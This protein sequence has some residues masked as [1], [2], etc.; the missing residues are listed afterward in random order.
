MLGKNC[1]APRKR[2]TAVQPP[3][4]AFADML[5][6]L[7]SSDQPRH[8]RGD[9]QLLRTIE[10]FSLVE[11]ATALKGNSKG[12]CADKHGVLLEMRV[13]GGELVQDVLL[14]I[15]NEI[16][17]TGIFPHDWYKLIF[18]MVPKSGDP[19]D[20]NN[21]RPIA[22]LDVVYKV[23]AKILYNRL[24][25]ILDPQQSDEQFGF[26]TDCGTDEALMILE[27]I[28]GA[29]LEWNL[30]LW[31]LSVDLRKAFDKLEHNALLS[32]LSELG[33][34]SEYVALLKC[35][36]SEQIGT[37]NGVSFPIYRGVRQGDI[38][39]P[40]L[41]NAATEVIMRRWKQRLRTHGFLLATGDDGR[42]LTNV[43]FA[44]DLVLFG[45]SF[46]EIEQM[47][48]ALIEEF[49]RAG[50]V[51]NGSKTKLLTTAPIATSSQTPLLA[52]VAGMFVEM[53]RGGCSHKY[54]G[55]ALSGD[56]RVRGQRNL[57]HRLQ[58]AWMRFHDLQHVLTNRKIPVHL[59]LQL[60]DSVVSPTVLYGL[61]TT[62]LTATQLDKLD[63]VQRKMLRRI[64]GWVRDGDED[65]AVTGHRM[66]HRLE[67]ALVQRP[68][69][70]WSHARNKQRNRIVQKI[71]TNRAPTIVCLVFRWY[72][73][74]V[75][76]TC[77]AY[78]HSGRP[79]C[80]WTD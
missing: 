26:R 74:P 5:E 22:I 28:T 35:I 48:E 12:T 76:A 8:E 45:K 20:A 52:D 37:V 1:A 50:L 21:W 53:V 34:P 18:V 75:S 24:F 13:N 38:L 69:P 31:A 10:K 39:S 3:A 70:Q 71:V 59:R 17:D 29:A 4:N 77:E 60:F 80:R 19:T 64:V 68:V 33:L 25:P 41:F 56:L 62:P 79:R 72:R 49:A 67:A 54:L 66:K 57:D 27:C 16:L 15:Y 7:Y 6:S 42:R 14:R 78:R 32:S 55:K 9:L 58:C 23:F 44:D 63:A 47:L 2:K 43:R 36:Y 73:R 40:M 51:V 30:P 61:S 65:W 11:L 46:A